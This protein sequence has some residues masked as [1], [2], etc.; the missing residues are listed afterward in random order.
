METL[1][2]DL[3]FDII[4]P[5]TPTHY[6]NDV[7]RRPNILDIALLKGVAL[8]L[9]CIGTL[10]CLNLDHQ[11]VLMRTV[12]DGRSRTVPANSDRK[13]LPRDVKELIRAKNAALR[14]ASK[15]PTCENRSQARAPSNVK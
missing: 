5:L 6:P 12:V 1:A 10:Q 4:T 2:V 15:Y 9:S 11:P 3:H 8:K 14:R 13:E 7:N